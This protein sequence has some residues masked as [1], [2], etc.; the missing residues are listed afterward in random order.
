MVDAETGE[1]LKSS[2]DPKHDQ[3]K[4]HR[5]QTVVE[6][7]SKIVPISKEEVAAIKNQSNAN[8]T[9]ASLILLGFKHQDAVPRHY[10]VEKSY[11]LYPNEQRISGSTVAFANLHAAMVRKGVAAI[12]E[13]LT[14]ATATSRLVAIYPQLEE[15]LSEEDGGIQVTP[16]GLV[17]VVL[18]FEDDVRA[19]DEDSGAASEDSI[20]AATDLIKHMNYPDVELGLDFKND[21]LAHFWT[22]IESVAL[23]TTL[24]P[25]KVS[26]TQID[27]EAVQEFAG[28]QIAEFFKTL[29]EDII[30]E[31]PSKKR[32]IEPNESGEY[33]WD[34]L[35]Q[36]D[37]LSKCTGDMLR[38]FLK[39]EGA[40]VSGKKDELVERASQILSGRTT[41]EV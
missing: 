26:A 40:K 17:A 24:E 33:D 16:P 39:S 1:V 28:K 38:Q 30:E 23:E 20:Q 37:S 6:F 29:P 4:A 27:E 9:D 32:K 15:V 11:Y 14:K 21:A 22:Y 7:G 34:N 12:G 13:L 3:R 35:Y 10:A 19:L 5:L 18:P 31:K 2:R 41:G 25:P 8:R 36:T